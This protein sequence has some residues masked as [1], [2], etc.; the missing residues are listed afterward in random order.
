MADDGAQVAD[1]HEAAE[2]MCA[3]LRSIAATRKGVAHGTRD[4]LFT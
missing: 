2:K 3:V 1:S 4:C